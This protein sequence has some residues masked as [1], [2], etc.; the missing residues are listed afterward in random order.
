MDDP[1]TAAEI[2]DAEGLSALGSD[3]ATGPPSVDDLRRPSLEFAKFR[4]FVL[5]ADDENVAAVEIRIGVSGTQ[6]LRVVAIVE[7]LFATLLVQ[8]V[9]PSGR[10]G[11]RE[12]LGSPLGHVELQSMVVGDA[13]G[14]AVLRYGVEA[15][16]RYW[17]CGVGT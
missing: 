11:K 8:S 17:V 14:L 6:I 2:D 15:E 3:E 16:E 9:G 10:T 5:I 4:Q 1:K 12:A 7:K 13:S